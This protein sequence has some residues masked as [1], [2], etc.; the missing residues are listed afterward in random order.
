MADIQ[1]RLPIKIVDDSTG[2][3]AAVTASQALKV[4]GSAVTQ[5]VSGTITLTPSGTQTVTGTVTV[6]PSGTQTVTGTVTIVPSGTQTV[7]G[8]VTAVPSGTTTVTGTVT[9]VPSGTTSTSDTND[10]VDNAGFTD[11]T[12]KVKMAGFIYDDVAG[13][14]LTENDAA[15]ARINPN[16]AQVFVIEDETTRGRRVTVTASNALKVDGSAVTQPVSGTITLTP[17]GTQ[18]VTG[19]VT[20]VPSGTQTV[21]GTVTA[22]SSGT[23]TVTGTVT[24]VPSG[25]QTVTGTV[26]AVPSGTYTTVVVP[27]ATG[28][29]CTYGTVTSVAN[30]STGTVSYTVTVGK[31]FYLKGVI[32]SSSGAPCK[33]TV[34]Y[35]AGPTVVAVGFYAASAPFIEIPFY[36]SP[37]IAAS[38][39][40][41]VKIQNNAGSAQDVYTTIMGQE[42]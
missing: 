27:Y 37:G 40:V 8:T 41:N 32:A 23:T 33:V 25:T 6:V 17:S 29:V 13:T 5:P 10:I 14:A 19:T 28:I 15:A 21:T 39:V 35:G 34:D 24:T 31:T 11:G 38:T 20:I 1:T 42:L 30:A 26:T 16:R 7:T 12:S 22:V 4:D 18:T 2:T 9:T 3:A 36:E